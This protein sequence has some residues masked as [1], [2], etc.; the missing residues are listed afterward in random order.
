LK[1]VVPVPLWIA[2]PV[3]LMSGA[4]WIALFM[5]TFAITAVVMIGYC[6][7]SLVR[8]RQS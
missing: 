1:P 7:V 3:Y 6:I 2:V 4:V 8:R 5:L